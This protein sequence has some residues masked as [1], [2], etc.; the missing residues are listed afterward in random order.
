MSQSVL[1]GW[2]ISNSSQKFVLVQKTFLNSCSKSM[3]LVK[4][5]DFFKNIIHQNERG[6][7]LVYG[8][9]VLVETKRQNLKV[10]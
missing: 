9:N 7:L 3:K 4:N 8:L 5:F 10:I 1:F 2:V 6:F